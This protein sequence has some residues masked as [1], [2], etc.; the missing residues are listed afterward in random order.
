MR[1]VYRGKNA[2]S[3]LKDYFVNPDLICNLANRLVPLNLSALDFRAEKRFAGL[4]TQESY[5]SMPLANESDKKTASS[6]N[7]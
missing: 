3:A 2:I 1:R 6:H 7:R 5:D 4:A